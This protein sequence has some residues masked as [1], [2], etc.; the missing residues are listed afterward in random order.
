MLADAG[1]RGEAAGF[2]A[3]AGIGVEELQGLQRVAADLVVVGVLDGVGGGDDVVLVEAVDGAAVDPIG[4]VAAGGDMGGEEGLLQVELDHDAA[5][6][7]DVALVADEVAHGVDDDFGVA[8]VVGD[9]VEGEV[10]HYV[11]VASDDGVAAVLEQPAGGLLL[12]GVGLDGVLDAPVD[13][14]D[15]EV[16]S[17]LAGRAQVAGHL[18]GVD[19]VD[20]VGADGGDAVGAVGVGEQCEADAASVNDEGVVTVALVAVAVGAEVGNAEGVEHAEGALQARTA[21]VHAVVVGG[22]EDIETGV[23]GGHGQLARRRE[24]GVAGVGRAGQGDFEVEDGQVGALDVVLH[25]AEA[26]RVVVGAVGPKGGLDLRPM[27]HE[28]AGEDELQTLRPEGG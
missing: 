19:E 3:G 4:H 15:D 26:G 2:E 11:G 20:D 18:G 10:L 23:A 28:V 21:T 9:G 13:E 27:T 7:V 5:V 22:G 25:I 12:L 14:G 24:L 17:F 8:V 1:V 6:G 16:G